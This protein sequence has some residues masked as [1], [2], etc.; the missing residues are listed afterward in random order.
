MRHR[1]SALRHD[2]TTAAGRLRANGSYALISALMLTAAI[3]ANVAVFLVLGRTLLRTFPFD[4]AR[5][6]MV[7]TTHAD[8]EG[9]QQELPSGS[10]DLV[11]W[12]TSP[13]V[14]RLDVARVFPGSISDR[15]ATE[16][17]KVASVSGGIFKLFGVAPAMGRD[18]EEADDRPDATAIILADHFWRRQFGADR[19][20]AGRSLVVDGAPRVVLGVMP[21]D[22]EIPGSRADVYVPA[23]FSLANMPNPPSRAY[24]TFARLKPGVTVAEATADL[25]R[26]SSEM[27][28]KFPASHQDFSAIAKPLREA[29]YGERRTALITLLVAVLL[30]HLLA[31]LNVAN[32]MLAQISD[33]HT[34]T[35]VRMAMGARTGNILRYR[36]IEALL[37]SGVSAI[38][39]VLLGSLAVRLILRSYADRDLLAPAP[40]ETTVVVWAIVALTV[41]TTMVIALIPALR[42]SRTPLSAALNEGTQR[43][44]SSARGRRLRQM[45]IIAEVALAIPL[46][47]GA[48]AAVKKFQ[49][50]RSVDIGFNPEG[51]MTAQLIM[52]P[53]YDREARARFAAE[54]V[55]RLE[56]SPGVE[57]AAITTSNFRINGGASTI[58]RSETMSD[59]A[60]VGFRR[61]TPR[62]FETMSTPIVAG[63]AFNDGDLA[64]A[65]H[66]AIVSESFARQFWPGQNPLGQVLF[67][68]ALN[69]APLRVVGVV[70]DIRDIGV[71]EDPGPTLYSSFLQNNFIYVSLV[72]R[73]TG[74]P[75]PMAEA[76]KKTVQSIDPQLAPDEVIPF[77]QLVGETLGSYKLQVTLMGGFAVIALA[78]AVSG[79]FAVTA[80]SVSR[81]M[82]EIGIRM[83]FG[84]SH[85]AVVGELVSDTAKSVLVGIAVGVAVT[86]L[87]IVPAVET[88][89]LAAVVS[90][91]AATSVVA[92]LLPSL[93]ARAARPADLLR[94][95]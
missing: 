18:F 75:A 28:V 65:P 2:I 25:R 58:V 19:D 52:P 82:P 59:Y 73:S 79:I 86:M 16:A 68:Q 64:D 80:Y 26:I 84:A 7:Y 88:G 91:L 38:A 94:Q 74:D 27:A 17:V 11:H 55:R 1:L 5:M 41:L 8:A 34:M 61:I 10:A 46:L 50:L 57:S 78:L 67:R 92:S 31:C 62:F 4:E 85:G 81:R 47:A 37:L 32:L 48:A 49:E 9:K 3:A 51:L 33:Q 29:L 69:A 43:S 40:G 71:G 12:R 83:A 56:A 66:V 76:I 30:V 35:A 77:S 90:A 42:E 23:G 63:R 87:S 6:V 60:T 53:R 45:F 14:E 89:Y 36:L 22:F 93:R 15:G 72:V 13:A 20:I 44:S 21:P 39:G 54:I 95:A 24:S 70:P